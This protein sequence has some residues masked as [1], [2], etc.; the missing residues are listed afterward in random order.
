MFVVV[1]YHETN[2]YGPFK[3]EEEAKKWIKQFITKHSL[4]PNDDNE[5]MVHK[6]LEP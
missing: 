1:D 3:D 6:L 5:L 4:D 2:Y